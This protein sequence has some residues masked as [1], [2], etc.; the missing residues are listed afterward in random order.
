MEPIRNAHNLTLYWV[1]PKSMHRRF[2]LHSGEHEYASLEFQSAFGS[3]A[4][5]TTAEAA[6][7]FKRMGFFNPLYRVGAEAMM[8]DLVLPV[9]VMR[10]G[11]GSAAAH[12]S[13]RAGMLRTGVDTTTRSA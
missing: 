5:A 8:A 7:S 13:T 4:I 2:L 9:S 1:Q 3:L 6:W 10:R 11:R 12:S